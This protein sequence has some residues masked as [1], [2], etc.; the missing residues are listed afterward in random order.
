MVFRNPQF[1]WLS[2]KIAQSIWTNDQKITN[3]EKNN[4]AI[5]R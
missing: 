5:L 2:G 1:W 3:P 4:E